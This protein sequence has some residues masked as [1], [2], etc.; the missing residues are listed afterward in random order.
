MFIK[1]SLC[2]H[3]MYFTIK[4]SPIQ[5]KGAFATK[6]IPKG[7]RIIEYVGERISHEEADSRYDDQAMDRHHTFL[8]AVTDDICIDGAIGKNDAKYIN[9]SCDPNC[10][11]TIENERVYI[12]A[13][14]DI[15]PGEELF[16]DYA[17]DRDGTETEEDEKHYK[18]KCGTAKCRGS[19]LAP[20][21]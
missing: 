11:A 1:D 19:I 21:E 4:N 7:T 16:Y 8:F 6:F 10:E 2:P 15:K 5:G 20:K 9:H 13:I 12:D 3:T 17:Y 18:C 14:K